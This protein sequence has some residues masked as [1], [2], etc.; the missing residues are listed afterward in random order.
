M[1]ECQGLFFRKPAT[2]NKKIA[3]WYQL[4]VISRGAPCGRPDQGRHKACPY[5]RPQSYRWRRVVETM[6]KAGFAEF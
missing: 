6:I 4:S 5:K 3:I 1:F 2:K